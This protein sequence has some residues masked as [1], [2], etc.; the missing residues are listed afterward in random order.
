VLTSQ[1][2]FIGHWDSHYQTRL[3]IVSR[4][5]FRIHPFIVVCVLECISCDAGL[6]LFLSTRGRVRHELPH[7]HW[8]VWTP[9]MKN[10]ALFWYG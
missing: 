6:L 10:K 9:W 3:F 8:N 2:F 1:V 5:C 4:P 7:E